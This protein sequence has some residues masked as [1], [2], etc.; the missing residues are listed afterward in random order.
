MDIKTSTTNVSLEEYDKIEHELYEQLKAD[1]SSVKLTCPRCGE[2]LEFQELGN[3]YM[4][5]CSTPGCISY[6]VRG[7]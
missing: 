3:S 6:G 2:R 5:T 7:L 4:I 1:A